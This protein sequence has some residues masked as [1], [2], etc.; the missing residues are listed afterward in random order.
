MVLNLKL[1]QVAKAQVFFFKMRAQNPLCH[2]LTVW[3]QASSWA[4][5]GL[6]VFICETVTTTTHL[7]GLF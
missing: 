2:Q 6:S 7:T 1:T 4:S 3:L 5:L